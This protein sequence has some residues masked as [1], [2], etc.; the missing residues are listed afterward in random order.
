MSDS[1]KPMSI[2]DR[3]VQGYLKPKLHPLFEGYAKA[4][5]ISESTALNII[6]RDFFSRM[7]ERDKLDYLRHSRGNKGG[8]NHL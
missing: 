4:N 3:R 1:N 5:E 8:G 6:V 2:Q 7:P